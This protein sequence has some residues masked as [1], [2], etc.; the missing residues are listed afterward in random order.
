MFMM[1]NNF[2]GNIFPRGIAFKFELSLSDRNEV[3]KRP[4]QG[5]LE[6]SKIENLHLNLYL[7]VVYHGSNLSSLA[8]IVK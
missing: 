8:F 6:P 1:K 7:V 4:S 2:Q 5:G 3:N